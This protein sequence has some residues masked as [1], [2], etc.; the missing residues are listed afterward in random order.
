VWPFGLGFLSFM[1]IFRLGFRHCILR[2]SRVG[3]RT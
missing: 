3:R 1:M 2:S